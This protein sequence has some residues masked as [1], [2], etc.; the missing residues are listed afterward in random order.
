MFAGSERVVA[1]QAIVDNEALV[2]L[3]PKAA[4]VQTHIEAG[5]TEGFNHRRSR[6]FE[7]HV[8]RNCCRSPREREHRDRA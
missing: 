3:A 6:C 1:A 8:R 7:R 2:S 5:P 4:S